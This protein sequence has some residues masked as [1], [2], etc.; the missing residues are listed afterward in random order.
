MTNDKNKIN[1]LVAGDDD[2]TVELEFSSAGYDD[3]GAA[4]A[5]ANTYDTRRVSGRDSS[6]GMSVSAL[7]S[8]LRTRNETISQLQYDIQ[9]LRSK[10]VGLETEVGAREEQTGQLNSELS[11][12]RDIVARKDK[13]LKKRDRSIKSLKSEIRQRNEDYRQLSIRLSELQLV[14]AAT[15][16]ETEDDPGPDED[17]QRQFARMEA[18][19]DS[20]RQ[21]SQDLIESGSLAERDIDHLSHQLDEASGKN[22]Q[23]SEDLVNSNTTVDKLQSDMGDIQDRHG[24]EIRMLCFELGSA[25][26]TVVETG[27]LNTQL[28]SD[29]IDAGGLQNQLKGTLEELEEQSTARIN[30]LQKEVRK[31]QRTTDSYAQKLTTKSEAISVLLAELAKKN[32]QKESIGEIEDVIY[33]IDERIS[34]RSSPNEPAEQNSSMERTTRVLIGTVDDQILSFPLFKARLTIGRTRDNDIQ[35]RAGYIS[36]RHA[37]IQ[38]DDGKTRIIDWGSKNGIQVNSRKVSEHSLCH[39]DTVTIGDARFRYEE[40]KKRDS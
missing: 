16:P 13:L 33:D 26:D 25:Q 15:Q 8:D 6:L 37:V 27:D 1:E 12:S 9:Q 4:E 40:R 35:I 20:L 2:P 39:G 23:L 34:D 19:A 18:Y 10:W 22:A 28:A 24:E 21:Q 29:L 3:D 30:A 17:L 14:S 38:T 32:E 11:S 31:L 7:R 5:E 36:R